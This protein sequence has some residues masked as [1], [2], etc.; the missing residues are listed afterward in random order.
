[1][2][3]ATLHTSESGLSPKQSTL[4]SVFRGLVRQYGI[5]VK[6]NE[7]FPVVSE[8]VALDIEHD[9][10]GGFVGMG[11][12][13]RSANTAYYWSDPILLNSVD[14]SALSVIAHNGISDIE[15]MR[16]WGFPITYDQLVWD[17][18]LIGHVIDSS[19]KAYGLKDMAKREL[20]I[21]YPEY[22]E[23]VGKHK[24]KTTK[25][26]KCPRLR[27]DCCGRLTLDKQPME[28]TALYNTMDVFVTSRIAERQSK[29]VGF[30]LFP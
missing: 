6:I 23:I 19:L 16:F 12:F 9:E 11:L 21:E 2:E 13:I 24:G 29:H 15:T 30:K 10:R 28:L 1:M 14:F 20:G 18:M 22:D 27:S 3:L 4:L 8:P 17:T 25:A 26:P 7:S 5:Q